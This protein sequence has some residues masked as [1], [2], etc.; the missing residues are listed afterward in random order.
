MDTLI[1]TNECSIIYGNFKGKPNQ[2]LFRCPRDLD[3]IDLSRFVDENRTL[4]GFED[5]DTKDLRD[6]EGGTLIG[7]WRMYYRDGWAGRW[8]F[9]GELRP[10]QLDCYGVNEIIDWVIENFPRGCDGSMK[11]YMDR[12][13]RKWGGNERYLIK[14]TKSNIYKVMIDTTYGNADYPIRIYVYRK[15][16][17]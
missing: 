7:Y 4:V 6:V 13:Y 16:G 1:Q 8:M 5:D 11:E 14:P 2:E 12:N 17:E 15:D 10:T 3:D 9:Y